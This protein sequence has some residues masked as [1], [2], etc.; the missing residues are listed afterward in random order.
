MT[1]GIIGAMESEVALLK[2]K[3]EL[4]RTE[5]IS[6]LQFHI[7]TLAGKNVI[8]VMSS[9][10]KVN[11]ALCAQT[12]AQVYKV[13]RLVNVGVAGALDIRANIFATMMRV[14]VFLRTI[15][16]THRS[17]SLTTTCSGGR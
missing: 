12:L 6:G 10:G 14:W 5:E 16:P 8:V 7:G 2:E 17:L 9:V 11:A 1:W 15:L 4:E 13:D 3:M